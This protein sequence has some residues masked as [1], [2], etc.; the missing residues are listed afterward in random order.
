MCV[1]VPVICLST[2]FRLSGLMNRP[3]SLPV[4]LVLLLA[5][6]IDKIVTWVR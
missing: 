4:V 1:Q 3:L 6:P 2:F 5:R